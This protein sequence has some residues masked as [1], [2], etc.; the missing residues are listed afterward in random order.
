MEIFAIM[1]VG[2]I[3]NALLA[4][5]RGRSPM[6]WAV[7]GAFFPLISLLILAILRDLR[8]PDPLARPT[9]NLQPAL[10]PDAKACPRCAEHVKRAATICRFCGY[11]FQTAPTASRQAQS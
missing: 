2:A 7:L 10:P 11:D 6:G 3:L 1:L 5:G 4:K 8:D 9:P